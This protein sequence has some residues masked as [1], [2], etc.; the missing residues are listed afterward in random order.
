MGTS[1]TSGILKRVLP[2][3][4][5]EGNDLYLVYPSRK[6]NSPALSCYIDFALQ[7]AEIKDSYK[8]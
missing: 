4:E 8:K 3:W 6:L 2:D 1:L 5:P 7:Y